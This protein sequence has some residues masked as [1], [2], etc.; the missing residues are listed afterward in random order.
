VKHLL[1]QCARAKKIWE[2]LG[3]DQLIQ[4]ACTI[5][6][7]GQA[8]LD[9]ILCTKQRFTPLLGC[10]NI[11]ELVAIACWYLWWE[12]QQFTNGETFQDPSR[13][14]R[15]NDVL[16]SS[17]YAA[18]SPRAKPKRE[19]WTKPLCDHLKINGDASFDADELKGATGAVIRDCTGRFIAA[20]NTKLDFVQDV[21]LPESHAIKQGLLLAQII[22][23]NRIILT[24]VCMD[25]IS[26][27]KEGGQSSGVAAAI[28][29]DCY[30]LASEFPKIIFEHSF[31]E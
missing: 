14:A 29:D 23:C 6:R 15:S 28:F 18:N 30:H 25:A 22:G 26:V 24:S 20:G 8:V 12:R 13:A 10:A 4:S 16:Y 1:F 5:D 21:L 11:P 3:L 7:V 19:G 27:M 2:Q 9:Y 17:F 31:R